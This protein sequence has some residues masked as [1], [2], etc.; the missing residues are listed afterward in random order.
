MATPAWAN[1]PLDLG[2]GTGWVVFSDHYMM[3]FRSDPL[4]IEVGEPFALVLNVCTT[5]R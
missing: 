2:R 5:A 4:R 3:A 1:C